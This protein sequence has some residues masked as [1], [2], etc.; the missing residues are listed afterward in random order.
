MQAQSWLPGASFLEAQVESPVGLGNCGAQPFSPSI[1]VEPEQ[2]V[3]NTPTGLDVSVKLPQTTT[4]ESGGLAESA[5]KDT[6]V[7][8]PAG[9]LLSPSA[10]NGLQACPESSNGSYEGVGFTGYQKFHPDEATAETPTFTNT[11]RFSR[12][13]PEGPGGAKIEPSCPDGSKVGTVSIHTPDLPNPLTGDVYLAAQT[14]N[15]FG[16]LL[17]IYIVAEEKASKTLVKLAGEISP[18]PTTG[19]IS[20]TFRH[21]PQVPFDDLSLHLFGEGE[22]RASVTTPPL[23]SAENR[24]SGLFTPW[25]TRETISAALVAPFT[26]TSGAEGSGCPTARP[27]SPTLEAGTEN[28]QAGGFT[29]FAL[30]LQRPDADQ[31]PT[32]L[33]VHL[34][35]GI[36]G[37]LASVE[38]CDEADANAGTCPAGSLIGEATAT[39]GLGSNPFT[40]TGGQVFITEKYAGAPFGLSIVI[41]TK[42]GPFDF[43]N[44]VTR[45][46]ISVDPN[47]AAI[48]INTPD[49]PTM[50]DTTTHDTGVPVQLKQIHVVV[51]RP[52][53]QFNPTNC[54]QMAIVGDL[55]GKEGGTA[56]PS[57]R[58]AATNCAA[59][60]FKPK[61]TA[62]VGGKASKLN[63]AS[64]TVKLQSAGLG[65]AN[66]EKV[67]LTLPK[68]LPSRLTTIQK[69]C[70][71]TVFEVNPAACDEGSVIGYATIHTPVLK[72]ALSGPAY[73]VSHGNAGFP[74]VEFVLQGEGVKI[75]LDGKTDIK[76]GIT[77]SRFESAP[78]APFT[79]FETVLPT[80]PH[81]A[82]TANV[83]EK[84]NY[85]LCG[86][87]LEMP[88]EITAQNGAVIKQTTQIAISNCGVKGFKETRAQKL[89]KALKACRH[90]FKH[91]KHKRAS[92]EKTAH[93]KYG[94]KKASHKK[95]KKKK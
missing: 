39:A 34:P 86:T 79:T 23:C 54:K 63:G 19:Q 88:T 20:T 56:S 92:C 76:K 60:P 13:E 43:G 16:S 11:F 66:I 14:A 47:T 36:A 6:T 29:P 72:S 71:D 82:L 44:V 8:L 52:N 37:I 78:D 81:S 57:S 58:F 9:V 32:S 4:L 64:L 67:F 24:T 51:D 41:P 33:A 31:E 89:A 48:T 75:V 26:I 61:L 53:F 28:T 10:A 69:A 55:T 91:N 5:V 22:G 93:K 65:Q 59:L 90:K 27:F 15:P 35:P 77:Y 18:D 50:V 38:L 30:T 68:A 40:E 7:T 87:K 42:A 45:S 2:H 25:S 17:A 95:G 1:D 74:D 83:P 21:T 73:L 12:E 84:A 49:F 85:N 94:A 46:T 80:G 70:R 3:G 62:G